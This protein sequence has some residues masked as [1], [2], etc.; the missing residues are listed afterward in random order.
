ML[1]KIY[2]S[3]TIT[4]SCQSHYKRWALYMANFCSWLKLP[5]WRMR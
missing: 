5:R 3:F 2:S 1:E 4:K